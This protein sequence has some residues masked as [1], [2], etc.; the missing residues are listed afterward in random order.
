MAPLLIEPQLRP[1]SQ[2][3]SLESVSMEKSDG[4][5]MDDFESISVGGVCE[6]TFDG[7]TK[8]Y[9]GKPVSQKDNPAE[10]TAK[11]ST[12]RVTSSD[13]LN[14]IA[15]LFEWPSSAPEVRP[16]DLL[17]GIAKHNELKRRGSI[18]L[19]PAQDGNWL[20][21]MNVMK[22]NPDRGY[23]TLHGATEDEMDELLGH[24][25]KDFLLDVGALDFGTRATVDAETGRMRGQLAVKVKP[26]DLKTLALAYTLTR[27]VAVIKDFGM[28]L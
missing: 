23:F 4:G 22:F 19:V 5:T 13:E 24:S 21:P 25:F 28:D 7:E 16:V 8:D 15:G 17:N 20:A 3:G 6:V 18:S 12:F 2:L 10:Q 9:R 11:L 1:K 14:L 26:G 27:P